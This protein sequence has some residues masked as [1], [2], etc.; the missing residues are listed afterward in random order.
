M[1]ESQDA[2]DKLISRKRSFRKNIKRSGSG[3][4][5]ESGGEEE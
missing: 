1:Q 5:Q 4:Q 2:M 3:S